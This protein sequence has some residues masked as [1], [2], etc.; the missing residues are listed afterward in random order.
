MRHVAGLVVAIGLCGP[1]AC[2]AKAAPR[3][4]LDDLVRSDRTSL[5]ALYSGGAVTTPPPGFAPGRAIPDP[6]S[7]KTIRKSRTIG[8]LW[9]GKVFS[10]GQMINRLAGGREAVTASVYVGDSWLDGK[11]ALILDYAGSK[12]FG[13]VRDEMREVSPGVFVGLTY[14]RKCPAPKLAM[15]FALD[16]SPS[17]CGR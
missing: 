14:I 13:D 3:S 6:G 15:F 2:V 7:R 16:A 4:V 11:P 17:C 12:R 9:K 8:I 10:D 5:E 1:L